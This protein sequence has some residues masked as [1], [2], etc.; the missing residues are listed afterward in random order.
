MFRLSAVCLEIIGHIFAILHL[1]VEIVQ[2]IRLCSDI[3]EKGISF[4]QVGECL[5]CEFVCLIPVVACYVWHNLPFIF[6]GHTMSLGSLFFGC[7]MFF[8]GDISFVIPY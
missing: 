8:G 3:V 4:R 2:I 5:G 7:N 1:K 6:C